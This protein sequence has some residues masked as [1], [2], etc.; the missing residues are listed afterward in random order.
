MK[1]SMQY[2][3]Y[4]IHCAGLFSPSQSYTTVYKPTWPEVQRQSKSHYITI[5]NHNI[6][7]T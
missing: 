6:F 2:R 5:G 3:G 7:P 1:T 4:P